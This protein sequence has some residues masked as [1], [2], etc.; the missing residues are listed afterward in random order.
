[1]NLPKAAGFWTN[2]GL[3]AGVAAFAAALAPPLSAGEAAAMLG[4]WVKRDGDRIGSHSVSLRRVGDETQVEIA[5]ELKIGLG[6]ITLFRYEHEN[7]E[8][9]RDGRLLSLDA[10]THDDGE[11]TWVRARAGDAGLHVEGSAGS[12]LA[13][14]DTLPTSY[15]NKAMVGQTRLLDTQ[16]GRL[17]EVEVKPAG[18]ES[19][20]V[21]DRAIDAQRYEISGDL[22]ASLWY[23]SEDTWTGLAFTA[24]GSGI[25]YERWPDARGERSTAGR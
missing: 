3:A 19:I 24:R 7:R 18:R 6:F 11:D 1:M 23:D 20:V 14:A 21:G 15:W 4:F 10:R 16:S 17:I 9:W 12:Y 13:P 2:F 25:D 5:L 8:V 22:R